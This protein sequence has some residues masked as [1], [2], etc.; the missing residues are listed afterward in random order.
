MPAASSVSSSTCVASASGVPGGGPRKDACIG[1]LRASHTRRRS[2]SH[3]RPGARRPGS[4]A[5]HEC[6]APGTMYAC[7]AMRNCVSRPTYLN[8]GRMNVPIHLDIRTRVDLGRF[9]RAHVSR[10]EKGGALVRHTPLLLH[11]AAVHHLAHARHTPVS[12]QRGQRIKTYL[13]HPTYPRHGPPR[14]PR[15]S[16]AAAASRQGSWVPCGG[17]ARARRR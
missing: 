4:E 7:A 3:P 1:G 17:C 5:R 8:L 2:A 15:A 16:R 13:S 11:K 9:R 14:A 12:T 10:R 6:C